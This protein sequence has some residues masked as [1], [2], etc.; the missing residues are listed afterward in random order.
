MQFTIEVDAVT[1]SISQGEVITR[2][3]TI[4]SSVWVANRDLPLT[5]GSPLLTINN[6]GNIVIE[7]GKITYRVTENSLSENTSAI[8]LDSGNFVLR[9]GNFGIVWQSFDY[10]SDTL[11]PGMKFGYS[12]KSGKVWSLTSWKDA[13]DPN[14]GDAEL[15][16]DPKQSNE[17]FLT[18]GSGFLWRS[19]VWN[20]DHFS[21]MPLNYIFNYSFHSDENE[22][23]FTYSMK[24]STISRFQI[25]VS[26][27][28]RQLSWVQK[29]QA[30]FIFWSQPRDCS[31][32]A[33]CG[34]FGI[35]RNYTESL[36]Q[37]LRG[38]RASNNR[39]VQDTS[40]GCVRRTPLYCED[41]TS[42]KRD[43][44][45]FLRMD[46]VKFPLGP[47]E[48]K[49]SAVKQCESACFN[50]CSCTAYAHNSSGVCLLWGGELLN[51]EQ[52]SK[53]DPDGRTIYIKHAA[54]ELQKSR[55]N[56]SAENKL[57]QGGFGPVY[58]VAFL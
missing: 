7:D 8:L 21:Q 37:C 22:T 19:G 17:V 45:R 13:Q 10:P 42:L 23:Y 26:G 18:R 12:T 2:S 38:F 24:D 32:Y 30:W 5:A 44:D 35:C 36:C 20:G 34:P 46:A 31:I 49:A 11:L 14:L 28:I 58:K 47:K 43:K 50:E 1:D 27:G 41:S 48:L 40:S 29:S 52:L 53:R 55:D 9:N 3:E 33:Y 4:V 39:E 16:M 57:G 15:K 25:D 6:E 54:S 56:F 51:L